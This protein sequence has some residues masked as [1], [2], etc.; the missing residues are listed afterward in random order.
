MA[1][2]YQY[3]SADSHLQIPC[4]RWTP[5]VPEKYRDRAPRFVHLPDGSDGWIIEGRPLYQTGVGLCAGRPYEEWDPRG[6]SYNGAAGT[7]SPEQRL[8]EQDR[9]G[10]DAEVLFPGGGVFG[11]SIPDDDAYLAMVRAYNDFLAEDYCSVAPDR[12]IGV[13]M[14]PERGI[15]YSIPEMERCAKL[16]LKAVVLTTFPNGNYYPTP[17]DDEFWT[18]ALDLNMP[19]TVHE[20]IGARGAFRGPALQYPRQLGG[21][22]GG[23]DIC[24]RMTRYGCYGALT[25][26][27]M[28]MSGMFDRFPRLNVFFAE[29]QIGWIPNH[30]EQMDI[31]YGRHRFWAERLLGIKPLSRP[32]SEIVKEHCLWGFQDNPVGVH[33]RHFIGVD[34]VMW[35]TDFP[36]AETDWPNSRAVIERNFAGVPE[37]EKY[38]MVAGNAIKFFQL[39]NAA[40]A[41]ERSSRRAS[42]G[43]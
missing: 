19:V 32:P 28:V 1:R 30:L 24:V 17:E 38:K 10:I 41:T 43:A 37:D 34:K 7:G 42:V 36:H 27:Q 3:I 25:S 8:R 39:E 26:V 21:E 5:R 23:Q 2:N 29:N 11:E 16:G 31:H 33:L 35:A 13:G 15:Q 40:Q 22:L 12:L 18:A 6:Q 14:V 4:D 20:S 9:D